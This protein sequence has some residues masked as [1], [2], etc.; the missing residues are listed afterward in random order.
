MILTDDFKL[1]NSLKYPVGAKAVANHEL[2]DGPRL[3]S[4][5][6]LQVPLQLLLYN[7]NLRILLN[8]LLA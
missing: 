8:Y 3:Q 7:A 4:M 1:T 2:F 5:S 6:L